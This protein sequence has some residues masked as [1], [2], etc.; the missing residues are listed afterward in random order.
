MPKI[1]SSAVKIQSPSFVRARKTELLREIALVRQL[2]RLRCDDLAEAIWRG[3]GEKL[4]RLVRL[5]EPESGWPPDTDGARQQ[6]LPHPAT[7]SDVISEREL[8]RRSRPWFSTT[9]P[10]PK[11]ERPRLAPGANGN[12]NSPST[13]DSRTSKKSQSKFWEPLPCVPLPRQAADLTD[14]N[15]AINRRRILAGGPRGPPF[16]AG[17]A[18]N[19]PGTRSHP[20]NPLH[21]RNRPEPGGLGP[22]FVELPGTSTRRG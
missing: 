13:E 4:S 15:T 20:A 9:G 18:K 19:R 10:P 5:V 3:I 16:R 6:S 17:S 7:G 2:R 1:T 21:R 11:K 8:I 22:A 14:K 12:Q